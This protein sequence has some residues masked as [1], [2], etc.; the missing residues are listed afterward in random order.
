MYSPDPDN[1]N[2]LMLDF[3]YGTDPYLYHDYKFSPSNIALPDCGYVITADFSI[4]YDVSKVD[5]G[6]INGNYDAQIILW[7]FIL[8]YLANH[9]QDFVALSHILSNQSILSNYQSSNRAIL[10]PEVELS[11]IDKKQF[12]VG[13]RVH[14]SREFKKNEVGDAYLKSLQATIKFGRELGIPEF[15]PGSGESGGS[16]KYPLQTILNYVPFNFT[17]CTQFYSDQFTKAIGSIWE[18]SFTSGWYPSRG[19]ALVPIKHTYP[20]NQYSVPYWWRHTIQLNPINPEQE[21]PSTQPLGVEYALLEIP[22]NRI[23]YLKSVG[24]VADVTDRFY[25]LRGENS[26]NVGGMVMNAIESRAFQGLDHKYSTYCGDWS[27]YVSVLSE[28]EPLL[29]DL[30]SHKI[31]WYKILYI[32]LAADIFYAKYYQN[33]PYMCESWKGASDYDRYGILA[34]LIFNDPLALVELGFPPDKVEYYKGLFLSAEEKFLTEMEKAFYNKNHPKHRYVNNANWKIYF[35]GTPYFDL[36]WLNNPTPVPPNP[37]SPE[38]P[39]PTPPTQP[40]PGTFYTSAPFEV[41]NGQVYVS[42]TFANVSIAA[43][44]EIIITSIFS[45]RRQVSDVARVQ[46][47]SGSSIPSSN[48]LAKAAIS[49]GKPVYCGD[50]FVTAYNLVKTSANSIGVSSAFSTD[51]LVRSMGNM[52]KDSN[53]NVRIKNSPSFGLIPFKLYSPSGSDVTLTVTS[54]PVSILSL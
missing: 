23:E 6:S 34:Y 2:K 25:L 8:D 9:A 54:V 35:R 18:T 33:N 30:L 29:K 19:F 21:P 50:Y 1:V 26:R 16:R 27:Y 39:T 7:N 45:G 38:V 51:L 22:Q 37:F 13:K 48:P 36:N 41:Q 52:Y 24:L 44:G 10:I 47:Y 17:N 46:N 11:D 14:T 20:K 31:Q 40:S 32:P 49:G 4:I 53:G 12:L 5:D 42:G 15:D 3:R 28:Y 43:N